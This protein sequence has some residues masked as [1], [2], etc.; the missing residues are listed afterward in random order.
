MASPAPSVFASLTSSMSGSPS[1][2][3]THSSARGHSHSLPT[4][5]SSPLPLA[6]VASTG[7]SYNALHNK[8]NE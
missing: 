5:L 8:S 1:A 6:L 7:G 4:P 3:T 2:L